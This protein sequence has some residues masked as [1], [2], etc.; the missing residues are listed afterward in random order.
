MCIIIFSGVRNVNSRLANNFNS[1]IFNSLLELLDEIENVQSAGGLQWL[2]MLLFKITKPEQLNIVSSKCIELLTKISDE[3]SKKT[4]PYHLLLRSRY[5]LYGT[6]LEPE[7]FDIEPPTFFKPT[8][9]IPTYASIVAGETQPTTTD[10][11]SNQAFNKEYLDPK[12]VMANNIDVKI[13]LKNMTPSKLFKGLIESEPLHFICTSASD[14]T[15]LEKADVNT[16]VVM[17]GTTIPFSVTHTL[18]PTS[19]TKKVEL[20]HLFNELHEMPDI[21]KEEKGLSNGQGSSNSSNSIDA[22]YHMYISSDQLKKEIIDKC[23]K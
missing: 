4:N 8:S 13:K 16:K 17:N 18:I 1:V 22:V 23:R 14:G 5:G 2:M 20:E 10:F 19:G 12:D 7:L 9:M 15:R 21:N 11:Q 3:L 6:P